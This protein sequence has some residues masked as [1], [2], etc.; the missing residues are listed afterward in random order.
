MPKYR[1]YTEPGGNVRILHPN[2]KMRKLGESDDAFITRMGAHAETGDPSLA[3]LPFIDVPQSEV[4]ALDRAKR[5]KWRC[6]GLTCV[7]NNAIPDLPNPKQPLLDRI[8]AAPDMTALKAV[9][10]DIIKG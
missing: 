8:D 4:L 9:L 6:Q 5:H 1:V 3:G 2:E 7:V 10:K